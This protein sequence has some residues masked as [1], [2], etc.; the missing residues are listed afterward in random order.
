AYVLAD[1]MLTLFGLIHLNL[2][3]H[4]VNLQQYL[5]STLCVPYFSPDN[6]SLAGAIAYILLLLF[7]VWILYKKK[8]FI[9]V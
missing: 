8:I 1:V 2:V 6:A 9:K 4:R 5:Y 7:P 3:G